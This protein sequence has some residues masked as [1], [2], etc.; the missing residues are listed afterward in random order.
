M[1]FTIRLQFGEIR[2]T[3]IGEGMVERNGEPVSSS[4]KVLSK[5]GKI[6]LDR[7]VQSINGSVRFFSTVE[8][9]GRF[10]N[11]SQHI[12]IRPHM[13]ISYG[14]YVSANDIYIRNSIFEY[15]LQKVQL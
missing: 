6:F 5:H 12:S 8:Y 3:E 11:Q 9:T 10:V 1:D 13:D 14:V 4:L 2:H 7:T 15:K